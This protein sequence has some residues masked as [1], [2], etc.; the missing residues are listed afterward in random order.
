MPVIFTTSHEC[1]LVLFFYVDK[2]EGGNGLDHT[3]TC[4]TR[5][6]RSKNHLSACGQN[7]WERLTVTFGAITLEPS[8]TKFSRGGVQTCPPQSCWIPLKKVGKRPRERSTVAE[9][10]GGCEVT[11]MSAATPPFGR[12]VIF[13]S[14][15]DFCAQKMTV[16][17]IWI[18][19]QSVQQLTA[20]VHI[21][22]VTLRTQVSAFLS[23]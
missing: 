5:P 13:F 10:V 21:G 2:K 6:R 23:L 22:T 11:L 14:N 4:C 17:H 20:P 1:K 12:L 9:G 15:I 3:E 8:A 19:C 18:S 16:D 7:S